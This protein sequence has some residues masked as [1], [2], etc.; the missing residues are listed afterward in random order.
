MKQTDTKVAH[1][2]EI[3]IYLPAKDEIITFIAPSK[4]VLILMLFGDDAVDVI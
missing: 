3:A 2:I 4:L 1:E